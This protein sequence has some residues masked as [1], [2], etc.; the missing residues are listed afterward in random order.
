MIC[1]QQGLIWWWCLHGK[2]G[3]VCAGWCLWGT[4]MWGRWY[5]FWVG[6]GVASLWQQA[7]VPGVAR[8]ITNNSKSE[9]LCPDLKWFLITWCHLCI[10]QMVLLLKFRSQSKSRPIT[11]KSLFDHSKS[12]QVR[13]S[14]PHSFYFLYFLFM[15]HNIKYFGSSNLHQNYNL[16]ECMILVYCH[17]RNTTHQMSC[18]NILIC[19]PDE[20][21]LHCKAI[22]KK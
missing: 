10:F 14:D 17:R 19:S 6:S 2:T 1:K 22:P 21:P 9:H 20:S 18:C 8:Q 15:I 3:N 13:I 4:W 12:R 11:N 7:R 16:F 5:V